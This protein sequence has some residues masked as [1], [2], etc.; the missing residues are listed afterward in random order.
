[1][2]GA[3]EGVAGAPA[4]VLEAGAGAGGAAGVRAAAG[5]GVEGGCDEDVAADVDGAALGCMERLLGNLGGRD[6][7]IDSTFETMHTMNPFSSILY[8]SIVLGSCKILPEN[9]IAVSDVVAYLSPPLARYTVN[10]YGNPV[11]LETHQS[12]STS[13]EAHPILFPERSSP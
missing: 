10:H 12:R 7:G 5:A 6:G 11:C 9:G 2:A 13:G 3:G 1:M 4:A 8:D